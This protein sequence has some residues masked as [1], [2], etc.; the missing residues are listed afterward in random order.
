MVF[1][2]ANRIGVKLGGRVLSAN[3]MCGQQALPFA[4][5]V[6][7]HDDPPAPVGPLYG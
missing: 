4:L 3:F 5:F 7:K 2:K 6:Q 1:D